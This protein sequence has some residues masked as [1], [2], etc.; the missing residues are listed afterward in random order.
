MWAV[1]QWWKGGAEGELYIV[2]ERKRQRR[3]RERHRRKEK[4][5]ARK[6]ETGRRKEGGREGGAGLTSAWFNIL[7]YSVLRAS[8]VTRTRPS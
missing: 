4:E 1:N 3:E 8:R 5:R 7:R 6:Y 2:G